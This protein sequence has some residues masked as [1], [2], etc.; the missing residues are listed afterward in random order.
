MAF[1][2]GKSSPCQM[3]SEKGFDFVRAAAASML[4]MSIRW[5]AS[6]RTHVMFSVVGSG[7]AG[8]ESRPKRAAASMTSRSSGQRTRSC[9]RG[10]GN[11][12]ITTWLLLKYSRADECHCQGG[13]LARSGTASGNM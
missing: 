9:K 7:G 8:H 10:K 1:I 13:G 3:Y 4:W 12:S 2:S 11:I 5:N 6:R